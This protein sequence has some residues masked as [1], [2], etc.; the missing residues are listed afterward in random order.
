M[1]RKEKLT[2]TI[3]SV[4]ELKNALQPG[5]NTEVKRIEELLK[6]T[7]DESMKNMLGLRARELK[8]ESTMD[9]PEVMDKI[10]DIGYTIEYIV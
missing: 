6:V 1:T 8:A 4:N 7:T 10:T 2:E 5:E 3:K 9:L